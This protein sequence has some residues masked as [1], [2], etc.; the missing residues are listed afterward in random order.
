MTGAEV[1]G[2]V[3]NRLK[4]YKG[5]NV[6]TPKRMQVS[7]RLAGFRRPGQQ[8]L[9]FDRDPI[10]LHHD[11]ALRHRK[12]VGEYLHIVFFGGIELDNRAT[13]K[14]E[15]LVNRHFGRTEHNRDIERNAV[16]FWHSNPCCYDKKRRRQV[17]MVW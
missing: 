15:H 6:R 13:A 12:I 16:N 10:A 2:H 8:F 5:L 7:S 9:D 17:T 1:N 3:T 4:P 14:P 11:S